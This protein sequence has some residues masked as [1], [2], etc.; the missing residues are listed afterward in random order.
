[1]AAR[2]KQDTDALWELVKRVGAIETHL[3]A[4]QAKPD[5]SRLQL[6]VDK[7]EILTVQLTKHT[8]PTREEVALLKRTNR[9]LS[10]ELL[11]VHELLRK[12]NPD[13]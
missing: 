7:L 2:S 11:T 12:E 8:N 5:F 3:L 6:L 10:R 4:K 13:V 1:V 9:E